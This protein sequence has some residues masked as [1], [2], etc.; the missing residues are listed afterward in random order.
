MEMFDVEP[1]AAFE[2]LRRSA[3]ASLDGIAALAASHLVR[4]QGLLDWLGEARRA[5]K[6]GALLLLADARE[7]C[8]IA[9]ALLRSAPLPTACL[10]TY[11]PALFAAAGFADAR[12]I[13]A[14]DGTPAWLMRRSVA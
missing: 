4:S 9:D 8:A 3:D 1:V 12:R 13:D 6:P 5:L 10:A 11:S 2:A 7:P 14:A